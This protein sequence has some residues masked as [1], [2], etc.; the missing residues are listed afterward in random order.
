MR[1][2]RLVIPALVVAA[3][4]LAGCDDDAS[5][6]AAASSPAASQAEAA[7]AADGPADH[8]LG[9][10]PQDG[11]PDDAE[12]GALDPDA[13]HGPDDDAVTYPVTGSVLAPEC[14]VVVHH[15]IDHEVREQTF[16]RTAEGFECLTVVD[17]KGDALFF[18]D[19]IGAQLDEAGHEQTSWHGGD[20]S[21]DAVNAFSYL[22]DGGELFVTVRQAGPASLE[23]TYAFVS[24]ARG[25]G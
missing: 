7:P 13:G 1:R 12:G 14:G 24:P 9:D 8:A 6:D 3:L 25:N 19:E 23:T 4:V 22:V 11:V 18:A 15:P 5:N 16:D 10:G 2:P 20:D 21:A 17:S